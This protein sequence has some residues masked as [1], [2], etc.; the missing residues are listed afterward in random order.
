[1]GGALWMAPLAHLAS[2]PG[3][4]TRRLRWA[5][6][7][8]PP[9][10]PPEILWPS[11]PSALSLP[12]LLVAP[13]TDARPPCRPSPPPPSPPPP[14]ALAAPRTLLVHPHQAPRPARLTRAL[15]S[16]CLLLLVAW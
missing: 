14:C 2:P 10:Q 9:H 11:L 1:M 15:R 6:G 12:S 13:A 4:R 16:G 3:S 5:A 8:R 7:P